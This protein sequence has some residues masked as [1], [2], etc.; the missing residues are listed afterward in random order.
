[1]SEKASSQF[2]PRLWAALAIFF[3][4][5]L[6]FVPFLFS[7]SDTMLVALDQ[8]R[9]L[10]SWSIYAEYLRK[11]IVPVWWGSQLGGAP[12]FESLPGEGVYPPSVLL[13]LLGIGAK[14][15]G[16]SM[17]LHIVLAGF[18][19]YFLARRQFSVGRSSAVLLGVVWMFNPY[20]FSL[21]YGGHIGKVWILSVLPLMLLGVLRYMDTG[22]IRWAVLLAATL[23]WMLFSTHVQLVYFTLWGVFF[24]WLASLWTMR[25]EVKTLVVRGIGFWVA[26][27]F[28]LGLGAPI[29]LPSLGFI[30][31]STARGEDKM[32]DEE[33]F[34]RASSWSIHWEDVP[35]LVV[36]EFVGVTIR[37]ENSERP[38][39]E[40]TYWGGNSL[41]YNTEAPGVALLVLG[42]AAL[43]LAGSA[44]TW[45][46]A[47]FGVFAILFGL[48]AHT[49]ILKLCYELLP[50]VPKFRAPS[51]ILFWLAAGL[52]LGL[53]ALLQALDRLEGKSSAKVQKNILIA[54][55]VVGGLGLL[56][57]VSPNTP[58][59]IWTSI[60]SPLRPGFEP[61]TPALDGF[62]LGVLRA[63]LVGAGCLF[64]LRQVLAGSMKR[65]GAILAWLVLALVDLFG[66]NNRF[67]H[68][69]EVSREFEPCMSC[70]TLQSVPGKFRIMD[71]GGYQTGFHDFYHLENAGGFSDIG[72]KW[73]TKY[74]QANPLQGAQMVMENGRPTGAIQGAR[75]LDVLNVQF[76]LQRDSIGRE[77]LYVNKGVLP[78]AW[79][80]PRWRFAPED[81]VIPTLLDSG[82]DHRSEVVLLD[83]DKGKVPA[84]STDT[85]L[86]GTPAELADYQPGKIVAKVQAKVPSLLF[87]AD[88]WYSAWNATVDGVAA[89]V[90]RADLS[91]RA[92]PVP[93]GAHTVELRFHN[94]MVIRAWLIGAGMIGVL[95]VAS[96]LAW[97]RKVW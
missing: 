66:I 22:K 61:W 58:Y 64:V 21:I 65:E 40:V 20:M 45:T 89:P 13:M 12:V 68:T 36:P 47:G 6:L 69:T 76:L 63:G 28:G 2:K 81:R 87:V 49:P 7:S 78:R 57:F 50:G 95:L 17:W 5:T 56:F 62:R 55:A 91:F 32:S 60:F 8:T 31:K 70:Q 83:E 25:K 46:A 85:S 11:G 94:P 35:A 53:G 48:G 37:Q 73:Y 38:F 84:S 75:L 71:L 24:L 30:E 43:F 29:L 90:L 34:T 80:A 79:V 42:I 44:R 15:V 88:N 9:G 16:I 59:S 23:G 77:G 54:S 27:A 67:I 1:M 74:N 52:L 19:G 96:G 82:F 92:I 14:R 26:I 18:A 93:A 41:K 97:W 3:L 51:M 10:P 86:K 39:N 4:G 33:R 72:L